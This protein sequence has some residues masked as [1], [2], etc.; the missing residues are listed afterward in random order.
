MPDKT[1]KVTVN[2][3]IQ[4]VGFRPFVYRIALRHN[5]TGWVRNTNENVLIRVSGK[6][7]DLKGFLFDL[8]TEA[9]QAA[10]LESILT[11]EIRFEKFT[12]FEILKSH[13]ISDD[14]TEISP[15]IAVCSECLGDIEKQGNRLDYAFVNC[16]DCGPRF[17]IIKDL[18]Y[19]RPGTT[20]A[21]FVMCEDCRKEYETTTDRRFHAQPVACTICGPQYEFHAGKEPVSNDINVILEL[22]SSLIDKGGIIAVKGLGGIHLAC[23]AFNETAVARLR[24][25]KNR[26]GK[27]FAIMFRDLQTA[28]DH[29][30][31]NSTEEA[32]L[33]SWRSPIVLL[34]V[35]TRSQGPFLAKNL[36]SGLKLLGIMLPYMPL[37]YQLFR[38][39]KTEA[40]VLTSGNFSSEPIIIDNS[41][42]L[43]KF[44]PLTDAVLL[45]NRDIFNRTDDSVVRIICGK[46]RIFRRSRGYVPSP[47]RTGLNTEGIIAFGAELSNCFCVGKGRKAFLS[48]HI[49][50]LQGLE[51][52]LF[53]EQTLERFIRLF[54]VRP[55]LLVA[56]MHPDYI[57][58]RTAEG[59]GTP[60]L[61]HIQ[62]HH[63]HIASCMVE[64]K[65]DEKVIGVAF[66]GTGYGEDGHTWGSE[67]MVCDL[68]GYRRMSHLAY[69]PLPGGDT[70]S[71]EPWRMAVSWLYKVYGRKFLQLDLP[72]FRQ[73]KKTDLEMLLK[74]IDRKVNCPLT[75]G[76]G[77]Y[78]DAVASILGLCQV[79]DF[80][81]QGP[82]LL[83]SMVEAN[84]DESYPWSGINEISLDATLKG[85]VVD[86][87]NATDHSIIISKFHNT[88]SSVIFETVKRI[89]MA[90]GLKKVVL[91]GGVFQNKYLF[92]KTEGL[93]VR[94]GF[95]VFSHAAVPTNDGGIALGQLAV[96][97]KRRELCV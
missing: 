63:A 68:E 67:F 95:E 6:A 80:P 27:P 71:E 91:S 39:L 9:P 4:G 58:T 85:I 25:L 21:E 69:M 53:Y 90:E 17:T 42:A 19:D 55:T 59:F 97:A 86:V 64:N 61:I 74:M 36:N 45:H 92:E 81:A 34:Q 75:C 52:T 94:S 35:K 40:I 22:A 44:S 8:K 84:C 7:P 65:L 72:L 79:A 32:S 62:H 47:I 2:G 96:A 49:G 73:T 11:E 82:M 50:D 16:T 93:L 88:I 48:Q 56:D 70:A 1:L 38:K 30:E 60:D 37:H 57:S 76:A 28:K 41:E 3:L 20:M 26:E 15:D 5:L 29:A 83:E 23:D 24:E 66:D 18:P 77:R 13:D 33:T 31:I 12:S 51:T 87:A 14:I 43:E 89:S 46:E 10:S 78:F 54:R